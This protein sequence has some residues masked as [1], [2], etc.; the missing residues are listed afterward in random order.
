[1]VGLGRGRRENLGPDSSG[2]QAKVIVSDQNSRVY[3]SLCTATPNERNSEQ[4]SGPAGVS[5]ESESDAMATEVNRDV[6][7]A[8]KR[9]RSRQRAGDGDQRVDKF[10]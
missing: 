2:S 7:T 9:E 3:W 5:Q 6:P 8:S 4:M 1:M 10:R